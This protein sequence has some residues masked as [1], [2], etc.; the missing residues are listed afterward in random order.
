VVHPGTAVVADVFAALWEGIPTLSHVSLESLGVTAKDKVSAISDFDVAK[1][2]SQ[3]GK[4]LSNQR[5][6]LY[7]M[8][9]ADFEGV[10]LVSVAPTAIVI[11]KRYAE[12]ASV[13]E[14]R[15]RIGR[16]LEML[17]PEYVLA[18]TMDPVALE[19]VFLA[20]LKAYHPRHNRWR[21]GSEDSAAE[22]AVKL[23][24]ALPYKLAK[25]I[26]E[27]FQEHADLDLDGS[28]WRA[29]V[30]ETGN[31]AGLLLCG[32]LRPAAHLILRESGIGP[33]ETIG[34]DVVRE[35]AKKPGAFR[36]LLRFFVS[37]EHYDLRAVLGTAARA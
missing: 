7:V 21:A 24:K 23:K 28:P 16:A 3:A 9:D 35:H 15:F 12:E 19:D 13:P 18:A 14:L 8:A 34:P 17:R 10:R 11:S 31:R 33:S 22:E 5:A 30:L 1:I 27:I 4:A 6:G 26:A 37:S 36:E 25:R 32:Q 29:S 20:V 2:F